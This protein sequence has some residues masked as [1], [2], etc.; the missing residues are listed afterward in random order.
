MN[1][2]IEAIDAGHI[3]KGG[4]VA[5]E[6]GTCRTCNTTWPCAEIKTARETVR[7]TYGALKPARP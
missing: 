1:A 7:R 5:D 2:V 3:H 6:Q 4:P